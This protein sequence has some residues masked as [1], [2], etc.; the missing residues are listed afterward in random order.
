MASLNLVML[1]GN[2]TRTPELRYTETGSA[3][4]NVGLAISR[5][6]PD[7]NGGWREKVVFTDV[8]FFGSPAETI[9][10]YLQKGDRFF[11]EGELDQD[12]RIVFKDKPNQRE[13]RKTK[14][15]GR[16]FQFLPH[17]DSRGGK[18]EPAPI[19]P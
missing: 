8:V 6:V 10:K 15:F 9:C 13:E 17:A 14:I 18:H 11:A 12:I 5:R 2:V 19:T 7:G 16:R 3:V 4:T 1:M